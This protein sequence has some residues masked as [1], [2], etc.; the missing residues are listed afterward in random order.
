MSHNSPR[1]EDLIALNQEIAALVKAGVPLEFGLRGLAGLKT[2]RL[3]QLSDRLA[4]R[5]ASGRSLPDAMAEEGPVISPI[6]TAVMEA[7]LASGKLPQALESSAASGKVLLDVRKRVCLALVYPVLCLIFAY[8]LF[9]LFVTVVA[10]HLIGILSLYPQSWP[11]HLVRVLHQNQRYFTQV[12]PVSLLVFVAATFVL[13]KG[14]NEGL[15]RWITSF[16]WLIGPSLNWAQ[17]TELLALQVEQDC[18]LARAFVF[19][20]DAT[21]DRCWQREARLVSEDLIRGTTLAVALGQANSMPPLVRWMLASGESQGTL[22]L[23]L[24]QLSEIYRRRTL[25]RVAILKTWLPVAITICFTGGIGLI[26]GL[27][28]FLPLRAFLEGLMRE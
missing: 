21:D 7:G 24:R 19:A 10:S 11:V 20:A 9:C 2:S 22:A 18:P 16:R 25:R 14:P 23:T 28:F 5:L 8:L 1:L 26:Y 3:A 12:I 27:A 15:W 4:D 17:F 6:Y 13:R